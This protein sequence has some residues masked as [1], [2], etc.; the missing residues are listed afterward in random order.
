MVSPG[1]PERV[2]GALSIYASNPHGDLFPNS[3]KHI[4]CEEDADVRE[5]VRYIHLISLRARQ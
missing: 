5:R 4:V 1:L 3:Y 2:R